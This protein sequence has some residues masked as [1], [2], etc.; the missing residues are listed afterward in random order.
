MMM[1]GQPVRV[2]RVREYH[3]GGLGVKPPAPEGAF[4]GRIPILV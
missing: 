4:A 3:A 2:H 1:P